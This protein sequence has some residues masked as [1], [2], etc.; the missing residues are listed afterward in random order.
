M[1]RFTLLLATLLLMAAIATAQTTS[2]WGITAGATINEVHFKQHDI[3]PSTRA[4]GPQLGVTGEMNFSGIGFGVEASALYTLK[5]GKVNYGEKTVWSS[6]GAGN[7]TVSMHYLDVP[8]HLKFKWHR[9]GGLESTIMPLAYFGPQFSFLMHG[10]HGDLNKYTPVSVYL[11][12]G[13]GCELKERIQLR[14]GYNFSIG[15][16]F[17]TKML[18]ENVAKNRTWYFN[19]TYFLK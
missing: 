4:W 13:I 16:S 19:V 6:I 12:M 9:L 10:N 7:E 11:D 5:Q 15:Q 3:V 17:H 8:L 14:G 1:Q 2:R 18:D